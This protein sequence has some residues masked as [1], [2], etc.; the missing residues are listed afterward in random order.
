LSIQKGEREISLDTTRS[1]IRGRILGWRG[2]LWN[3]LD[4]KRTGLIG[5]IMRQSLIPVWRFG[6][7]ILFWRT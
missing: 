4:I 1:G 2:W 7:H 3:R 6:R 5:S